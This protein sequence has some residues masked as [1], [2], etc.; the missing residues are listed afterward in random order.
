MNC[1]EFGQRMHQCLDDRL[2]VDSDSQLCRH[3]TQ[4]ESCRAQ[5]L[6]WCQIATIMP[7][8]AAELGPTELRTS[9][10][11]KQSIGL[12]P[13]LSGLA[14]AMLIAVTSFWYPSD[15]GSATVDPGAVVGDSS[16]ADI[17]FVGMDDH[18]MV[19]AQAS[20]ELDPASWWR[21]VQDRDWVG[22]TMPAVQSLK[23][24]VAPIGRS[25]MRAVTILT[26][27]GH[28]QTS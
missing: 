25:L 20:G 17:D 18:E 7:G 14:A 8:R 4:C 9:H 11:S 5:M 15:P 3:A 21:N 28:A 13:T 27:G 23:D 1:E 19:L 12:I 6:A 22:Q 16:A 2:P 10:A 24:G 26:I